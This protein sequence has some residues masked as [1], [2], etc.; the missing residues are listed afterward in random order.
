MRIYS[1]P[2][3]KNIKSSTIAAA[4]QEYAEIIGRDRFGK[5]ASV[6]IVNCERMLPTQDGFDFN[7][8]IKVGDLRHTTLFTVYLEKQVKS[9]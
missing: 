7:A 1:C 8:I 2:G 5:D 6:H 9:E 4:S 3:Y